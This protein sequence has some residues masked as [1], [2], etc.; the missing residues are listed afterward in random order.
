VRTRSDAEGQA[1]LALMQAAGCEVTATHSG[2][3]KPP[4]REMLHLPHLPSKGTPYGHDNTV[5]NILH[6]VRERV[7]GRTQPDGSWNPTVRP[8][9]GAFNKPSLTQ[10]KRRVARYLPRHSLPISA[11][12]FVG[13][14][15]GQKRKRYEAAQA[16]LAVRPLA[17]SDSF[18]GV[19]LKY[20]KWFEDKAGRLISA[21]PPRYNLALGCFIQ[22]IEHAVYRAIDQVYGS[23]TIMKGYTPERR[24][25]VVAGHWAA[26]DD[27]VSVG[28][29]FSKFDQ[30]ISVEALQ[31]EHSFYQLCYDSPELARLLARQLKTTCY[32]T[33]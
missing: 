29:D 9:P 11:D 26:F 23:A 12:Q 5:A 28:Q 13:S 8:R 6:S 21:R 19:F 25:A 18:P 33:T 27:P 4:R 10:F 15:Q 1:D 30:H 16:S 24:A 22:P 3:Q 7:L 32:A 14:Y 2:S 20:E 31:F 17:V